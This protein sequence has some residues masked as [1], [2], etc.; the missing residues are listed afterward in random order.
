MV[1]KDQR[2]ACP[3]YSLPFQLQLDPSRITGTIRT[4][5]AVKEMSPHVRFRG[6]TNRF[7]PKGETPIRNRSSPN[8]V[9]SQLKLLRV[10]KLSLPRRALR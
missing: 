2:I 8:L 7:A 4:A 1:Q 10:R 9:N 6:R 3:T 5:F